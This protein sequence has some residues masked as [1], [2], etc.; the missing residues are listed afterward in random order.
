MGCFSSKGGSGRQT[1]VVARQP[2]ENGDPSVQ[3][4]SLTFEHFRSGGISKLAAQF[5]SLTSIKIDLG[6]EM[7]HTNWSPKDSQIV[8]LKKLPG[9]VDIDLTGCESISKKGVLG[10]SSQSGLIAT[11]ILTKCDLINN[12]AMVAFAGAFPN[13]KRLDLRGCRQLSDAG[14]AGIG[15]IISLTH[16]DLSP[17]VGISLWDEEADHEEKVTDSSMSD[18]ANLVNLRHLELEM[19]EEITNS[20]LYKLGSLSKLTYLNLS[21]TLVSD[22]GMSYILDH[23]KN[24]ESLRLGSCNVSDSPGM[25]EIAKMTSLTFLD[26]NNKEGISNSSWEKLSSLVNLTRLDV[27][28]GGQMTDE[29]IPGLKTLPALTWLDLG[30]CTGIT[31]EGVRRLAQFSMLKRLSL[32]RCDQVTDEGIAQLSALKSL[33]HL[34]VGTTGFRDV[35]VEGIR[36]IAG[37]KDITLHWVCK[38]ENNKLGELNNLG[39]NVHVV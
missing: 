17:Y 3:E 18:L 20:G 9:L 11:L 36:K 25:T 8:Q 24:I 4:M 13:L 28:F 19:C 6:N 16:L 12:S 27:S 14:V 23:H 31:D 10:V 26:L 37:L 39:A 1:D 15:R 32:N 7:D 29:G 5:S 30:G 35:Q 34:E 38:R 21:K 22:S 33:E 2:P